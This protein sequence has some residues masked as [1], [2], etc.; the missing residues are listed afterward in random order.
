DVTIDIFDARGT[1]VKT[2]VSH[3]AK[4]THQVAVP[5]QSLGKQ[6]FY[7]VKLSTGDKSQTVRVLK[8]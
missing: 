7:L 8:D 2:L 6:G 3:E 4:G 1:K 5:T